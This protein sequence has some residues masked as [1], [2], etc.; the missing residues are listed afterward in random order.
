MSSPLRNPP[1]PRRATLASQ[2]LSR[3]KLAA[4]FRSPLQT[5]MTSTSTQA[6]T[7]AFLGEDT[8][9]KIAGEPRA[10]YQTK[11]K[12]AQGPPTGTKKPIKPFVRSSR[13]AAQFRSPLVKIP[14]DTLRPLV[15][16]NQA[17]MNLERKVTILRR[18]TKIKRDGDEDH[19]ERLAKKWRE[20]G[21]EA[22]YEL[23]GIVRDLSTEGSE[24][25]GNGNGSGWGWDD[26]EKHC[27]SG[28][29]GLEA[30]EGGD[31]EE[32]QENTLGVM[33]RKLGIA[34]ETLGWNEVEEAFVDNE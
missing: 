22:A 7:P 28:E 12:S 32:K 33:L 25:R 2:K 17:L 27:T 30:E 3:K 16:P 9:E 11:S 13:V 29:D 10:E 34:P 21:R 31:V 14:V 24:I 6:T 26:Q 19:L 1:A 4:P 20:V 18:A 5:R 23:W 15:L 8:Q